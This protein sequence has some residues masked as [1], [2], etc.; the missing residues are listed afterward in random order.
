M[1]GD[2]RSSQDHPADGE[3]IMLMKLLEAEFEDLQ[4]QIGDS[5]PCSSPMKPCGRLLN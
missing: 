1:G 2:E 3:S 5:L 4:R